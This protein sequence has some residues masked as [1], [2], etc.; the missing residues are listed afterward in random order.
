M[1]VTGAETD[2]QI[3]ETECGMR[4]PDRVEPCGKNRAGRGLARDLMPGE[5][6]VDSKQ[7]REAA[8]EQRAL[9]S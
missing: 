7:W 6:V 2:F 3:E 9:C 8:I 5:E 1:D 4:Q